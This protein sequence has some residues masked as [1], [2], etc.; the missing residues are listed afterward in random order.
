MIE[1]ARWPSRA[2][3]GSRSLSPISIKWVQIEEARRR[4]VLRKNDIIANPFLSTGR[5]PFRMS[6]LP[7]VF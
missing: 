5:G 2:H 3:Y 1:R 4:G 7:C 6:P